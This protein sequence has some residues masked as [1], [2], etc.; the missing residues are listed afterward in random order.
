M[1]FWELLKVLARR[2]YVVVPV[3]LVSLVAAVLTSGRVDP[4]YQ[5]SGAV[6][7]MA[8]S[9]RTLSSSNAFLALGL[10]T[11]AE[12]LAI[13]SQDE[14]TRTLVKEAGGAP[15][16]SVAS[17]RRSP[18]LMIRAEGETPEQ[19][20]DTVGLLVNVVTRQLTERQDA[21]VAPRSS[22]INLQKL[23]SELVAAPVYKGAQRVKILVIGGGL[24][25]AALA[26][27]LLEGLA[28]MRRR[29]SEVL[30]ARNWYNLPLEERSQLL[31]A[32]LQLLDE[33]EQVLRERERLLSG[34]QPTAHLLGGAEGGPTAGTAGP[35]GHGVSNGH[36]G[37]S[38]T[39]T[40]PSSPPD[41]QTVPKAPFASDQPKHVV[42]GTPLTDM[43]PPPR[44]AALANRPARNGGR[45]RH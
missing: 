5:A 11:A 10:A 3:V 32:R 16:Y 23:N 31:S 17:T 1:D 26:A 34:V 41:L 22:R 24:A 20:V 8:P 6:V 9:D 15:T 28:V 40:P 43:Y 2:W 42:N 12:A 33:R 25:L 29:K 39:A 4:T 7:L 21:V 44:V 18:I 14:R 37:S 35:S 19:A 36:H 30:V 45:G 13:A 38:G 27:L